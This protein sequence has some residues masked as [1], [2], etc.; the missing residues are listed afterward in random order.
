MS[1]GY[2][3]VDFRG[4]KPRP[5]LSGTLPGIRSTIGRASPFDHDAIVAKA[6]RALRTKLGSGTLEA[7]LLPDQFT[8]PEL[9]RL[10]EAILGRP[11]DRRNF[12]KKM[13]ERSGVE[14][15]SK[16]RVGGAHRSPFL[17]RFGDATGSG[18]RS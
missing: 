11:L 5:D 3:L 1:I 18:R 14:R 2:A 13:L 17:Y 9:H 12:Q 10:H 6:L 7:S 15:L 16:R 4:V 8:M